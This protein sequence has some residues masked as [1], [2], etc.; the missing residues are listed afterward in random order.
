MGTEMS[1][2]LVR[3]NI[4]AAG[5]KPFIIRTSDGST[6]IVPHTDQLI[7]SSNGRQVAFFAANGALKLID[8]AHIVSVE[9]QNSKKKVQ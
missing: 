4:E 5:G 9:F 7:I 3:E 8:T 6:L 1:P 2:R